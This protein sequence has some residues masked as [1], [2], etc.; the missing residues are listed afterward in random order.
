M[1]SRKILVVLVIGLL[2]LAVGCS[3]RAQTVKQ[4]KKAK[5]TMEDVKKETGEM[6]ETAKSYTLEQRQAYQKELA[7]KFVKYEQDIEDLKQKMIMV[8]GDTE[9]KM[10][11]QIKLDVLRD[12]LADMESRAQELKDASG[13]AWDDLKKGLDKAGK[14]LVQTQA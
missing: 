4:E 11:E 3:E 5:T 2:S 10:Q 9:Q 14:D 12:K 6:V 1:R 7:D 13:D 8:S